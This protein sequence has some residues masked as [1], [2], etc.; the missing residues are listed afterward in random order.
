MKIKNILKFSALT[1]LL[2]AVSGCAEDKILSVD[3]NGIPQVGDYNIIVE[4]N[5]ETNEFTL[6]LD[7][8]DG[9]YPIWRIYSNAN[10]PTTPSTRSTSQIVS[11]VIRKAGDYAVELQ[12]GNH[13]GISEGSRTAYIHIVNDLSGSS[14]FTGYDYDSEYNMWKT[15]NVTL[16]STW[17]ANNDWS[18]L[19]P[20][21][22]IDFSNDYISLHTPSDMG[23]QQWQGQ[24]HIGTDIQV[25]SS[26]YYDFSC[27]VEAVVDTKITVKVQMDGDDN[28]YFVADQQ[29]FKAGGDVYY[30]SGLQGFDGNLK[31][32]FDFGGY[33]DTDFAISNIVFKNHKDDDGTIFPVYGYTYDQSDNLWKDATIS[34]IWTYFADA[35]WSGVS[36]PQYEIDNQYI[37]VSGLP[38]N[39][40]QWQGQLGMN[41][42]IPT[43][44]SKT[45]DFSV[46][47][48]ATEDH[49]GITVKLT[50]PDDDNH[51]ICAER[52]AVQANQPYLFYFTDLAGLDTSILKL[53]LDFGGATAGTD[54]T[55]QDF[56]LID[57]S[58]NTETISGSETGS[59]DVDESYE[60]PT[61]VSWSDENN[62][63]KG[64]DVSSFGFYDENWSQIADPTCER[65]GA[66]YK[67]YIEKA[68]AS[69]WMAQ[70][71]I[72]SDITSSSDNNY[73]FCITFT[74]TKDISGVMIKLH[75][76]GDD[77]TFYMEKEIA[78]TADT[79]T[80]YSVANLKGI[81]TGSTPL[82]LTLDFGGTPEDNE[83]SIGDIHFQIH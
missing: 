63:W 13:N 76:D 34:D 29:P 82:V 35:N 27:Y 30:F 73:D 21:P 48:T 81:D 18:E 32:V 58:L 15:A 66:D 19:S 70:M 72:T 28:T 25:S 74:T 79:P 57:H 2:F 38:E 3:I 14:D 54:V 55:L 31:I 5:D 11:G 43:S 49:P 62:L 64:Y 10:D 71:H 65:S 37:I 67:L 39:S 8:Y 20:Q 51:Y 61:D 41:L 1:G 59:D 42:N 36:D 4:V 22:S 6:S 80:T 44:S 53:V 52:F 17:F 12:I 60:N 7:N 75:P 23:S 68:A 78:V 56:V 16:Q 69:R 45:Y 24:V 77:S 83:V 50:D 47:I 40:S 46:V 9:I 33:P 26:E